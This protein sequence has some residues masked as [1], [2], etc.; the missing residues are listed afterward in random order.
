VSPENLLKFSEAL[1]QWAHPTGPVSI[2]PDAGV[3]EDGTPAYEVYFKTSDSSLCLP[4]EILES[5]VTLSISV[6]A[7][8]PA[9]MQLFLGNDTWTLRVGTEEVRSSV[10]V[11]SKTCLTQFGLRGE[12]GVKFLVGKLQLNYGDSS[13]PYAMTLG[14]SVLGD[15]PVAAVP[16]STDPSAILLLRRR[17]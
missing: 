14:K 4:V 9:E 12:V 5:E 16:T 8:R 15:G 2:E 6:R 3:F 13:R 7:N 10:S 11:S 1:S 17:S